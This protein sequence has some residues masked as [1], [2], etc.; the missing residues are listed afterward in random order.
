MDEQVDRPGQR[1]RLVAVAARLQRDALGERL[2][3]DALGAVAALAGHAE[4]AGQYPLARLPP[5]RVGFAGQQRLVHLQE[6]RFDHGAV[7][8][9]GLAGG[10]QDQVIEHDIAG[11]DFLN[12]S[13][14]AGAGLGFH[15]DRQALELP[16]G[17][18]FLGEAQHRVDDGHAADGDGALVFFQHEEGD[19]RR[20]DQ[21][22]EQR[23]DVPRE[24]AAV[25]RPA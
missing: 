14:A 15:Q 25:F 21:R 6:A 1:A 18:E 5:H 8:D 3:A 11:R 9:N 16:L 2:G 23:E 4:A 24:D 19:R 12:L 22:V 7:G 13:V 17:P 10:D 20:R